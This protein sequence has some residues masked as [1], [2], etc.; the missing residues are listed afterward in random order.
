MLT[1]I[2][3]SCVV[4]LSLA[5]ARPADACGDSAP[6]ELQ[7]AWRLES[8]DR[9]GVDFPADFFPVRWFIKGSKVLCGGQEIADLAAEAKATP[10]SI[11]LSPTDSKK[12]YE[13]IY[14]VEDDALKIC[15]NAS[16]EGVKERPTE[17][18]TKDKP[19]LRLLVLRRDKADAA[20]GTAGK[21]GFVGLQLRFDQDRK[22]VVVSGTLEKGPAEKAGMR[23]DDVVLKVSG[24]DVMDLHSAVDLVRQQKPGADLALHIRRDGKEQDV[25]IKVGVIPV[26]LLL[27]L[28]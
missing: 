26:A 14:S 17:F 13:G 27:D 1:A 7:G 10:K 24:V 22:E 21:H 3:C 19:K 15:L 12:T 25:T 11:D 18:S 16:S 4:A 9:D 20:D 2:A 23:K 28:D 6:D 8:V 5:P